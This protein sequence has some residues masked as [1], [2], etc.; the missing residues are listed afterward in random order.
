MLINVNKGIFPQA[1]V[2]TASIKFSI[3]D[4]TECWTAYLSSTCT[5]YFSI[6]NKAL[7]TNNL[8]KRIL[9]WSS[10]SEK[11]RLVV[12]TSVACYSKLVQIIMVNPLNRLI[13]THSKN[14]HI[15]LP[16]SLHTVQIAIPQIVKIR[17]TVP[18]F[19]YTDRK[20]GECLF[21]V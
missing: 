17:S 14:A 3:I 1:K 12:S 15:Y 2:S 18:L 16:W 4:W 11:K 7:H 20:S 19:L 9:S 10:Y 6:F 13:W 5:L 21:L 8:D